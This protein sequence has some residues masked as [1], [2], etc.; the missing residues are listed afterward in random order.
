M[1]AHSI[2]VKTIKELSPYCLFTDVHM[3]EDNAS[4]SE[5]DDF[6]SK[7]RSVSDANGFSSNITNDLNSAT[8]PRSHP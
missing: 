3:S 8:A 6:S 7:P 5:K 2:T 4:G 1:R